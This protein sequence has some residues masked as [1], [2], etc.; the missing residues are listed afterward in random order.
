MF[1]GEAKSP[2]GKNHWFKQIAGCDYFKKLVL[3]KNFLVFFF[4]Y[5]TR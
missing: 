1:F 4:S 2:Q 3:L 5:T